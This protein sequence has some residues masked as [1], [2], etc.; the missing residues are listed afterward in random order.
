MFFLTNQHQAMLILQGILFGTISGF[1]GQFSKIIN[2]RFFYLSF[3]LC[4]EA[5]EFFWQNI[6]LF[7]V[8]QLF[9]EGDTTAQ[10]SKATL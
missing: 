2:N 3:G 5:W 9:C 8:R 4:R 6:Y 7:L 1:G 10:T